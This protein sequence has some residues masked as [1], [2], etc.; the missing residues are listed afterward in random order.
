MS[1]DDQLQEILDEVQSFLEKLIN[2]NKNTLSNENYFEVKTTIAYKTFRLG[3]I[4]GSYNESLQGLIH[5]YMFEKKI[6]HKILDKDKLKNVSEIVKDNPEL[7]YHPGG[8]DQSD[9]IDE[10]Y[11]ECISFVGKKLTSMGHELDSA[12]E[13]YLED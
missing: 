10:I 12:F 11:W 3:W 2:E 6:Y 13:E 8:E 4:E 9:L 7:I 5:H 1:D